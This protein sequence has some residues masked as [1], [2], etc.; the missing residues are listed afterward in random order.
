MGIQSAGSPNSRIVKLRLENR[1]KNTIWV[2]PL[3]WVTKNTIRG[4][5]MASPKS[6]PWWVLWICVSL[7]F[8]R[9]LK[10]LQLCINQLVVWFMQL[11]QIMT[12]L[13]LVLV[14]KVFLH[15]P[16]NLPTI[17]V[18]DENVKSQANFQIHEFHFQMQCQ[19]KATSNEL[20]HNKCWLPPRILHSCIQSTWPCV[21][22]IIH[23]W[24]I[25][26][27]ACLVIKS[28]GTSK[29]VPYPPF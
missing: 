1:E 4:K 27:C 3:R 2:Y 13:S 14:P 26:W 7:W 19:M 18:W 25:I 20:L 8:I 16:W 24:L 11:I 28:N 22:F 9:A 29:F 6:K 5:V 21:H 10:M 23:V 12:H 15:A 17:C